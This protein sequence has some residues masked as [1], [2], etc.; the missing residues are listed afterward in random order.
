MF[1]YCGNNPI[2]YIDIC[3]SIYIENHP[4]ELEPAVE[5]GNNG[6]GFSVDY[7]NDFL[8]P[9]YCLEYAYEIVEVYGNG[10][11]F[12]E[13]DA[14]RIAM[15]IYSHAVFHD[16]GISLNNSVSLILTGMGTS[17]TSLPVFSSQDYY[18]SNESRLG[19]WLIKK[20]ANI[21]VNN[22]ETAIRVIAYN[23]LWLNNTDQ[24]KVNRVFFSHHPRAYEVYSVKS[25]ANGKITHTTM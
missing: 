21:Y 14:E 20:S 13:M 7:S 2:H 6:H 19:N 24:K 8:N 17:D 1:A 11:S 9:Y 22:N 18:S 3:G 4:V 16:T 10:F 15:E 12:R 5:G 23:V 25:G